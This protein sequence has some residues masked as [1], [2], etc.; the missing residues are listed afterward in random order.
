MDFLPNTAVGRL[1]TNGRDDGMHLT[2]NKG[3][4]TVKNCSFLG[5]MD[6]PV[7]VHGCCVT[8]E[9]A[10]DKKT[11]RCRYRHRQAQNFLYWAEAGDE[12]TFLDRA[13]MV[14]LGTATAAEYRLKSP[15][16]FLL[17]FAR[18]LPEEILALA[19]NKEKLAL[20][21]TSN[22]ASFTCEN[23]RFGSCRA[24]GI[25]VSTPKEVNIKNNF[26]ASSGSAILVAGDSNEWFESG[27]CHRVEITGNTFS[28]DCCSSFYQFCHGVISLCPAVPKPEATLP[29]HRHIRIAENTFDTPG[30]P[31]VYAFSCGDLTFEKNRIFCNPKNQKN[32]ET[33][34]LLSHCIRVKIAE[35]HWVGFP[36]GPKISTEHCLEIQDFDKGER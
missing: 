29:Y 19:A 23:N 8:A 4:I 28:Q 7:N 6:D 16:T 5:L 27:A 35:N 32:L 15:D 24:R 33:S 26:F 9:E 12:I 10:I 13:T 25:L 31:P 3:H 21:N 11:L 22:T 2:C 30:T 1:V 14:S 18:E 17:R 36:E 20:D 34:I